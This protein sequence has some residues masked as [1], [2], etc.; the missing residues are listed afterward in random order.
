[1]GLEGVYKWGTHLPRP[2]RALVR[3]LVNRCFE[4]FGYSLAGFL[5]G[6]DF[7]QGE[8]EPEVCQTIIRV[9]QPGWVCADVG[10]YQGVVTQHL[11]RRVGPTGRVVAFE[12]HPQNWAVLHERIQNS[13]Y[14]RW[15]IVEHLAVSDGTQPRLWLYP[16]RQRSGAEWNIVGHDV[17][18]DPT[19]REIE[20]PATSLDAYFP[21][22]ERLDF[23]KIDVEGA[24]ALV[25]VGMR[26][27]LQEV[28]PAVLVEFHDEAGW[29]GRVE[30]L[31]ARYHLYA[32]DG[33]R[34]D[35]TR[36]TVRLYHCL[37][38]PEEAT[39][40]WPSNLGTKASKKNA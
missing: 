25:L 26:R 28:R 40:A 3:P 30:L 9:V 33:R 31:T 34:L 18:G 38:L 10:A 1:M 7:C 24:E 12:V 4:L 2:M 22:G 6:K 27:L 37:A 5:R 23:V 32:L 14:A 19:E 17:E 29:A 35:P 15:V 16:G 13:A 21:L 39:S 8:Y 20:V 11:A 36:D